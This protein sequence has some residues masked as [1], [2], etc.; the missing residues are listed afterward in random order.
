[1]GQ[2]GH[3]APQ[4]DTAPRTAVT[5]RQ[6]TLRYQPIFDLTAVPV[7]G[8]EALLRWSHPTGGRPAAR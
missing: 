2:S 8:F 4:I 7:A 6:F 5:E 3:D 1:M